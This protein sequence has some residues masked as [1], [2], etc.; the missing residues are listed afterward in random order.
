MV[1]ITHNSDHH[2]INSW[3]GSTRGKPHRYELHTDREVHTGRHKEEYIYGQ[4]EIITDGSVGVVSK[5]R[6]TTAVG[7]GVNHS[8]YELHTDREVHTGRHKEE[9]IYGQLEQ[10]EIFTDGSV[11]VVKA[12]R[13]YLQQERPL[14]RPLLPSGDRVSCWTSIHEG[15]E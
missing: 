12:S 9:C 13:G 10:H 2:R 14:P 4:H 3:H 15:A 6:L 7:P 8:R 11:G 5:Q 1:W